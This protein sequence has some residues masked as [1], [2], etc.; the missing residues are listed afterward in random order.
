MVLILTVITSVLG[1]FNISAYEYES[2]IL[3][4]NIEWTRTY[5]GDEFDMF[6]CVHQT[7][8]QG[9]IVSGVTEIS[10]DYYPVLMKLNSFGDEEWRWFIQQISYEDA[11]YDILDVYPIFSNQISDGGYLFCLWLDIEYLE[12][13]RTIAGLFKFNEDGLLEWNCF[14][15]EGFA[16]V[17]RPI[18]FIEVEDGFVVAGTSGEASSYM[19]DEAGLLKTDMLGNEQWYKE[20]DFGDVDN[21]DNRMEA[22]CKTSDGGFILTGWGSDTSYDYWMIKTDE[23][24]N[25]LWDKIFGGPDDDYGHSKNCYQT[26]DGGYI[27]AG[28]SSS[29]GAGGFDLWVVKSDS[30]GDMLWNKTYGGKKNDVCWGMT[31]T[32]DDEYIAVVTMNYAGFSGDRDDIYLV[33]IDGNGNIVWIQKY[34]GPDIQLG[35]SVDAT[36][37]GGFIVSGCTGSFH[38]SRSDGLLVKFSSFEN[39]RPDKPEK[40]SGP[41]RGDIEKEYAFST[42]SSDPDGNQLLYLWDWGDG[43]FTEGNATE[44]YTW[45]S[46]AVFKVRVMAIDE[47]GG[48]S[49]WSDPL[50]FSTPRNK[51]DYLFYILFEKLLQQIPFLR[52]PDLLH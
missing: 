16:W 46:K 3:P 41:K 44:S 51:K 49:D 12:I 21:Y 22:V 14:Y 36:S 15:S 48:E 39:H 26:N 32:D 33:N 9:Y 40:P 27:M 20:Y 8:D 28:F 17:F 7:S 31:S 29:L 50:K 38:S 6:H 34:G 30:D 11:V 23:Y 18:S 25:L 42:K 5:G 10:N 52:L 47:N 4:S 35:G 45:G 19:G 13:M 1:I 43:N 37:D 24:G 2:S